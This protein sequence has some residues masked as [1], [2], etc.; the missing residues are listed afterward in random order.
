MFITS[1]LFQSQRK[2]K[3]TYE[4]SQNKTKEEANTKRLSESTY[5]KMPM[6]LKNNDFYNGN[7]SVLFEI[8]MIEGL[9][10]RETLFRIEHQ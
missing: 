9:S 4:S 1:A 7:K 6:L 8:S 5:Q 3:V 10:R 2:I